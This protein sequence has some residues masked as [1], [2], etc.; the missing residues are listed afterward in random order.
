MVIY[1]GDNT[2]V[3]ILLCVC[4]FIEKLLKFKVKKIYIP[5]VAEFYESSLL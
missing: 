2:Q 3:E 4:A 5:A 1:K